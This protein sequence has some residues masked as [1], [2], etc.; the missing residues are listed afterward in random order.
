MIEVKVFP[1]KHKIE[2]TGHAEHD[3]PGKDVVCAAASMLFYT[4]AE[5]VSSYPDKV[6]ERTPY[7]DS[8]DKNVVICTPKKE[9]PYHICAYGLLFTNIND[10]KQRWPQIMSERWSLHI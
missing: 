7:L 1:K 3:E 8:G 9:W 4:L 5:T 6:F 10:E 2:M